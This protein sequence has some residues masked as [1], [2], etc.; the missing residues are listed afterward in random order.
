MVRAFQGSRASALPSSACGPFR[1]IWRAGTAARAALTVL[2][3]IVVGCGSGDSA[4]TG[5]TA[6]QLRLVTT[7]VA[8]TNLTTNASTTRRR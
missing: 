1:Y 6:Q 8:V 3:S 5:V 2:V 4:A 7:I